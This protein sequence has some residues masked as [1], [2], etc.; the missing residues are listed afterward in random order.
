[1]ELSVQEDLVIK[2][3]DFGFTT[4]QAK[5]YLSIIESGSISVAKIAQNTH[6]H[7]QDIYKILPKLEK[8]GLITKTLEK[9]VQIKAIPAEKALTHLLSTEKEKAQKRLSYLEC[10]INELMGSIK[11]AQYS[12]LPD[13]DSCFV[14]LVTAK[15]VKNQAELT[16]AN[17]ISSCDLVVTLD[18]IK[19]LMSRLSQNFERFN[20]SNVK[21]R[22]II[23]SPSPL[24]D[25]LTSL[26]NALPKNAK[27]T[28]K[29]VY[30]KQP[31]PYYVIDRTEVWISMDKE[32]EAGLPCVLW[33]KGKNIVSFFQECFNEAWEKPNAITIY[34]LNEKS[35]LTEIIAP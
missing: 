33:T 28:A 8:M 9:P 2:L 7:V 25:A 21:V 3:S 5:V 4:N 29:Y 11:K 27:I 16:F 26:Q 20:N 1:V 30:K 13:K 34:P 23:E 15:Q 6:L 10:N 19:T 12:E 32:T 17:A 35:K 31:V 22:L 18:L 14:L 24:K